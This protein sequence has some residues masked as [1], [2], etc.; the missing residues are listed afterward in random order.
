MKH[1]F[2]PI[3]LAL[4]FLSFAQ[5][6]LPPIGEWRE[7]LPYNK[8]IDI[9]HGEGKIFCATPYSLFTVG[10]SDNIIERKSKMS[11][12]SETGISAINYNSG[13]EKLFIAYTN[14]NI[15]ILYRNDIYN[16]PD[17]KIDNI[18]GDKTIYAVYNYGEDFYL[19]SGLGVIVIDGS[20]YEV[21][22]SWFIGNGGNQVKVNGFAD[23]G[24]F[25]YAATEEG[26]K[27]AP[28]NSSGLADYTNWQL[29]SGNNGL[30][31]GSS[32]DVITITGKVVVQK[33]DSLFIQ[34][35][36]N[37]DFLYSDG[38]MISRIRSSENKILIN[39][40]NATA[41]RIVVL[42]IDA[43]IDRVIADAS[44]RSSENSLLLNNNLWIADR[45]NGLIYVGQG[46][47]GSIYNLNSPAGIAQGEIIFSND[48]FLGASGTV[49]STWSG[50]ND[51]Q[52][53]YSYT[54]GEW[55]NY[56]LKTNP[57]F[58]S[59]PDIITLKTDPRDESI[60]AGS[61][62]GGLLHISQGPVFEI[63]KQNFL[64]PA[65]GN[66]QGYRVSGLAFDSENNLWVSNYGATQSLRIRK[67]NGDWRSFTPPF[68]ISGNAMSQIIVDDY[69]YKWIVSPL[70]NGLF[71][72]DH[73]TDI[74]NTADDRWK[75]FYA[76]QGNGGLPENN[77][78]CV[79]KDKNGFIWI[80]TSNGIGVI[81]CPGDVFTANGCEAIL[82]IVSN[83]NFAGYLF[84]GQEVR[85]IAVDGANRKWVATAKGVFLVSDD[86]EEVIYQ[87]TEEN[88]KLLSNDVR[89]ITIDGKAGE[90][91][92]AT[93]KGVCS[94]RS[95]ATEGG[96]TNENVLV[97]PNPVP[98]GYSGSIA[99]RGL[100]E[101]AI[102][103]ITEL[104]GRL[105]YQTKALGG[106]AI[107]DG[108]NYR[109]Q[110]VSSGAYL[111]LVNNDGRTERLATKIFFIR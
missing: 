9:C 84:N 99:I 4:S 58:D 65:S 90:V 3:S 88:S 81:E 5:Q 78:L 23:D 38:W 25:F 43:G 26:L 57:L 111:V 74:D 11:G 83:G 28:V 59:L 95:T 68:F 20:R 17:I 77:V 49:N 89:W 44:L 100:T 102:V 15:D 33:N 53:I 52:G 12:L 54:S 24:Q 56:N 106:Q 109:G 101:N 45:T 40:K 110:K 105:V 34:N 6:P 29:M 55:V 104:D 60:W 36:N 63:Y 66:P 98:P 61:F 37:W 39:E 94:F 93:A 14:S 97:F 86:G 2:F 62:G 103:K 76:G 71:C 27:K 48:K 19:S 107:W 73:G 31:T 64:E 51:K 7:Q 30:S 42:N 1:I 82:P 75:R 13:S 70:G 10:L 46:S 8:A 72:F 108:R 67:A 50:Q 69:N 32:A 79:A 16:I 18:I 96:E 35:G 41:G 92:F 21:K 91:F 22:D 87:F 47:Q 85:S 80:G